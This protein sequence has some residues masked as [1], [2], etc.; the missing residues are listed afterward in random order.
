MGLLLYL[1]QR[2][3][4]TEERDKAN[5]ILTPFLCLFLIVPPRIKGHTIHLFA[6][7]EA[8]DGF[9]RRIVHNQILKPLVVV[10]LLQSGVLASA[11]DFEVDGFYYNVLSET[12]LTVE[13]TSG[14]EKYSGD[15]VIPTTVSHDSKTYAVKSIGKSAFSYCYYLGSVNIPE[16]IITID[17]LAFFICN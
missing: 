11:Y 4:K 2:Y 10:L 15:V 3:A 12:G 16:S 1:S 9:L 6:M 17:T 7:R 8:F 14:D 13:I 5:I